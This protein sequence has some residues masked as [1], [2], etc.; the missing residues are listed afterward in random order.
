MAP[1]ELRFKWEPDIIDDESVESLPPLAP[2]CPQHVQPDGLT[3]QKLGTL[4]DCLVNRAKNLFLLRVVWPK[5]FC[6][7]LFNWI[8]QGHAN[9]TGSNV[10]FEKISCRGFAG[11][12]PA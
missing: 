12:F 10:T 7:L 2:L 8:R 9:G 11:A 4:P 5:D 3:S 1:Q 6:H